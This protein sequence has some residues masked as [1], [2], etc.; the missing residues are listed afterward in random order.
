MS[1]IGWVKFHASIKISS[2]IYHIYTREHVE[3]CPRWQNT[4]TI[5]AVVG[6]KNGANALVVKLGVA[7]YFQEGYQ[8]LLLLSPF[9]PALIE[10]SYSSEDSSIS[11]SRYSLLSS[12]SNLAGFTLHGT[13]RKSLYLYCEDASG[14]R[15]P[16]LFSSSSSSSVRRKKTISAIFRESWSLACRNDGFERGGFL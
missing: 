14:T 10:P 15:L 11:L 8:L 9:L 2:S 7:S 12:A 6:F 16:S 13:L 4:N 1:T 5:G 3:N